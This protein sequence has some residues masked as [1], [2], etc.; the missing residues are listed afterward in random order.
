MKNILVVLLIILAFLG[1][2]FLSQNYNFKLETKNPSPTPTVGEIITAPTSIIQIS[3]TLK[4]VENDE[5][6]IKTALVEKHGWNSD[7]I[8]VTV[9]KNNGQFARGGVTEKSSEVGGGMFLAK[10]TNRQW[11]I[12]FDGNGVPDCSKLKTTYLFPAV[13]LTGICD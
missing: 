12:I 10:K 13:I 2:Y 3:P 4:P 7:D 8:I 6:M 1:G 9:S 5:E 11:E